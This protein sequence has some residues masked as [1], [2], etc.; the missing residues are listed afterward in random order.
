MGNEI[1][2]SRNTKTV[3]FSFVKYRVGMLAWLN[4]G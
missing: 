4:I 3:L 1:I 2:A